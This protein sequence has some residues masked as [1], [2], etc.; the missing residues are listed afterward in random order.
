[1]SVNGPEKSQSSTFLSYFT[2]QIRATR[3]ALHDVT[4]GQQLRFANVNTLLSYTTATFIVGL[5]MK[6]AQQQASV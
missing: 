2:F 3:E 6:T 1:M 4:K 5:K